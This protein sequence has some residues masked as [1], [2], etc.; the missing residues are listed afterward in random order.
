MKKHSPH[1]NPPIGFFKKQHLIN[2][3]ATE[4]ALILGK[5][6]APE[7]VKDWTYGIFLR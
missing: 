3:N 6:I 7:L 1:V 4:D 2:R 5:Y